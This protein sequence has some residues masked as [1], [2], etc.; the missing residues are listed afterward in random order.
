MDMKRVNV[1]YDL[2]SDSYPTTPKVGC[3]VIVPIVVELPYVPNV[4]AVKL[5]DP[6]AVCPH[7]GDEYE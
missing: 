4:C 7:M 1:V 5:D 2:T 3:S 6:P